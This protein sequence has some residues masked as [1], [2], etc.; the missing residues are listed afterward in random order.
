MDQML[1][2]RING[3]LEADWRPVIEREVGL[4]LA[5]VRAR[6]VQARLEF[7]DVRLPGRDHEGYL[8][9]FRGEDRAGEVYA[10]E[11]L[12]ADGR[13]AIQYTLVRVRRAV[14]RRRR[15]PRPG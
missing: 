6:F 12:S 2:L 5:P 15:L 1:R 13:T 8:C 14:A 7:A 3:N 10:A 11:A 9:R 4:R